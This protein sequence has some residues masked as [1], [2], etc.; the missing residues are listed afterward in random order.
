M[1][2]DKDAVKKAIDELP[3]SA[4][5]EDIHKAVE[6][7]CMLEEAKS[8]DAEAAPEAPEVEAAKK[9]DDEAEAE[10]A[11]CD[12]PAAPAAA[13]AEPPPADAEQLP[14]PESDEEIKQVAASEEAL[15]LLKDAT[16]LSDD[17]AALAFL[18]DNKDAIG[19]LAGKQPESGQP[20]DA[21]PL[22]ASTQA[23]GIALKAATEALTARDA[24]I[25]TLKAE[26]AVLSARVAGYDAE[27]KAKAEAAAK[28]QAESRVE[29]LIAS[30]RA[31][32][33]QRGWLVSLAQTT[34]AAFEQFFSTA[35]QVVPT[36]TVA[37]GTAAPAESKPF[38]GSEEEIA[39]HE[40]ALAHVPGYRDPAKRRKAAEE[41]VRK[42]HEKRATREMNRRA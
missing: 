40:R 6:A 30:G 2:I 37:V 26:V 17:A 23:D 15:S 28:A 21:S 31:L 29:A 25:A 32:D 27:A 20:S 13:L 16:G 11:P 36:G 38:A 22:T 39:A 42:F 41:A 35:P 18:R 10:A 8:G 3:D 1:K 5:A 14:L 19:A 9:P 12:A 24:A 4:S 7:A 34:P 33:T